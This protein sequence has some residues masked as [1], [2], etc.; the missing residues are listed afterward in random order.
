[1][2]SQKALSNLIEAWPDDPANFELQAFA[3]SLADERPVLGAPALDRIE[4]RLNDEIRRHAPLTPGPSR[5]RHL[6]GLVLPAIRGVAPYAA[7]ACLIL[8]AAIWMTKPH[9]AGPAPK[10]DGTLITNQPPQWQPAEP[11]DAA[12]QPKPSPTGG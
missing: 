10:S 9:P 3:A 4:A 12:A 2:P 1:M 6:T 8:A 11:E 5:W 7:A